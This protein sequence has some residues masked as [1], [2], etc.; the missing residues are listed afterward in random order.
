M[1]RDSRDRFTK[2]RDYIDEGE[3]ELARAEDEDR[4][5]SVEEITAVTDQLRDV[6]EKAARR[7]M[8]SSGDLHV[9]IGHASSKPPGSLRQRIAE[10]GTRAKVMAMLAAAAALASAAKATFDLVSDLRR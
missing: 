5:S 1:A 10:S 6:V 4:D 8:Q 9:H 2:A 3:R 7:P